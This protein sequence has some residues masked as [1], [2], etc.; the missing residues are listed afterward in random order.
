MLRSKTWYITVF[1]SINFLRYLET[2]KWNAISLTFSRKNKSEV[3][4]TSKGAIGELSTSHC[5]K[6]CRRYY[7]VNTLVTVVLLKVVHVSVSVTQLLLTFII[8]ADVYRHVLTIK[9]IVLTISRFFVKDCARHFCCKPIKYVSRWL[10]VIK[11]RLRR[12]YN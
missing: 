9:K 2:W 5:S 3:S 12:V 7:H 11:N 8:Q 10:A 1:V 6:T 4:S